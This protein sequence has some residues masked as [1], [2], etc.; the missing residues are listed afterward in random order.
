MEANMDKLNE[1]NTESRFNEDGAE[2]IM[3]VAQA[4]KVDAVICT[5]ESVQFVR[6]LHRLADQ[7]PVIVATANADTYD[8]LSQMN[9]EVIRLPLR[10]ADKYKQTRHVISMAIRSA[11]ISIGERVLCTLAWDRAPDEGNFAV[12]TDVESNLEYLAVADLLKLTDGIRPSVL[13]TAITVACKVGRAARR[14]KRIGTIFMLGD[15]VKVLE[16]SKQIIPNP[17]HGHDEAM[18]RI[19]NPDIHDA[20]V[21]LAKLDGAFVVR[22]DGLIQTAG[23]FLASASVEIELPPGLGARHVA[24]ASVTKRTAAT[25]VV[26]SATDGNVRVFSEGKLVLQIDPDVPDGPPASKD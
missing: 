11:R 9:F 15:S 4:A 7:I 1:H 3:R 2:M 17:F 23:T 20:L 14:G 21:E 8:A 26:V 25:A 19:S 16:G 24:A 6:H 5:T 12:L 10:A 18:R 13:E 22:G